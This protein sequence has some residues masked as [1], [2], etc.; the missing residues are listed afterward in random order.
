M[1]YKH[2]IL[3]VSETG[4]RGMEEINSES[5]NMLEAAED[6][7]VNVVLEE[8]SEISKTIREQKMI[9][10]YQTL[11][12]DGK[13]LITSEEFLRSL[14]PR[15]AERLISAKRKFLEEHPILVNQALQGLQTGQ[16]GG[17]G[18]PESPAA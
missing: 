9:L 16:P 13:P 15:D 11:G 4:E 14:L 17:Q 10:A 5:E 12:E 7:I 1:I 6:S 3:T 2:K 8:N 18:L